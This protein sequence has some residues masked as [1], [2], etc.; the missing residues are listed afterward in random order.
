MVILASAFDIPL[1]DKS[2][3]MVVTSP[4][5]F[6]L[7][8]YAN[9]TEN[10]FGREE[11]EAAYVQRSVECLREI[12][13]VLVDD[14]VVFWVIGDSYDDKSLRLVPF[15]VAEAA[16]QDGWILRDVIIWHKPNCIPESVRDRCTC[17]Y[18]LI[19]VLA[20]QKKNYWNHDEAREPAV[21]TSGKM[22]PPIGN[23]KHQAMG[24]ATLKGNRTLL[25]KTRN[26]RN[27]WSIPTQAHKDAHVAM[28]PEKLVELCIHCGSKEGDTVLDPFAGSGTTGL[29]AR[30]LNRKVILLDIS[31]EYVRL[32]GE[33]LK[34]KP[35]L[36]EEPVGKFPTDTDSESDCQMNFEYS[37]FPAR[38]QLTRTPQ[39]RLESEYAGE[40]V[41]R[42][43]IVFEKAACQFVALPPLEL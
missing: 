39:Q 21:S 41:R 3:Q 24:K 14:G 31:P 34:V 30:F 28:F 42:K 4:P 22:S 18:E 27:V 20:K 7:R 37:T 13:R 25:K 36:I 35:I 16:K 26:M 29:V 9:G 43:F 17:S 15:Q 6:N 32:M 5:Y 1:P 38:D 11:T 19:P 8:K 40:R 12:R 2:V 10:D 33:R 23:A